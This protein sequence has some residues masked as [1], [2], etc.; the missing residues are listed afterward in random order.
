MLTSLITYLI[1]EIYV[2]IAGLNSLISVTKTA[3]QK[4]ELFLGVKRF[5]IVFFKFLYHLL[6]I[7]GLSFFE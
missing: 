3:L 1:I 6:K 2:P 4:Q 5:K 7:E